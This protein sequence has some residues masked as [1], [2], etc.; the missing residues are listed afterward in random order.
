MKGMPHWR[1][2][3][4]VNIPLN[5]NGA[6]QLELVSFMSPTAPSAAFMCASEQLLQ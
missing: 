6:P 2:A 5:A 1:E 3:P 4:R